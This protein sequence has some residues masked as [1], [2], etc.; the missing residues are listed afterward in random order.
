[1]RLRVLMLC[2]VLV[3]VSLTQF[4]AQHPLAAPLAFYRQAT[5]GNSDSHR[6]KREAKEGIWRARALRAVHT[7]I[8]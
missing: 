8:G 2:F 7:H 6:H 4:I 1:M 3:V 5:V